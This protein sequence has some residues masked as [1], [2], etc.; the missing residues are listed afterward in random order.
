MRGTP[1]RF[2]NF[3]GG[4]NTKDAAYLVAENEC[5]DVRNIVST[6]RGCIR[7]RFGNQSFCSTFTGTPSNLMSLYGLNV[8]ATALITTGAAKMY[9]VSTGGVSTDITGAASITSNARWEF[10][11]AAVSGGQGPLYGVNGT[12]TPKQWTGSGNI[13]DWT[14]SVG[15]VPNGKYI[16]YFKNRVWIAGTTAN[17]SRLFFSD[18]GDPRSWISADYWSG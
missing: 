7:K 17:P 16:L 9:S 18:L 6:F 8:G 12:D 13:A 5:R 11:Q 14:A 4:V 2:T 15:S 3:S 1:I 10:T